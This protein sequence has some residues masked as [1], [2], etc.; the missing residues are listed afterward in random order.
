MRHP[1][2]RFRGLQWRL[3]LSYTLVTLLAILALE[4][5]VVA[6]LLWRYG[7]EQSSGNLPRIALGVLVSAVL[8]TPVFGLLGTLFGYAWTRWLTGRLRRLSDIVDAWGR[9]DLEVVARDTSDDEI[10]QLARKLNRMAEQLQMLL[11]TRRELAIVQERQRLARDLHDAVKQQVFATAMQLGAAQAV[12]DDDPGAARDLIVGAEQLVNQTQQELT[13][14]IRELRPAAL[15]DKGLAAALAGAVDDWSR[16]T[17]IAAE[18]R[19]QGERETPLIVEQALFRVAQEALAN[20]SRH[21]RA[22]SIE[23][24]LA[25]D[26]DGLTLTVTDN[27]RGFDFEGVDGKGLGLSS[28]RERVEAIGGAF[29]IGST[30]RGTRVEARVTLVRAGVL[31]AGTGREPHE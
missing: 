15:T 6:L 30:S 4:A 5:T 27:G 8:L 29:S 31:S 21:S 16:R 3:T 9:G 13:T 19:V 14:L 28:M 7:S 24:R 18:L 12:V 25:W 23:V 1:F 11:E 10:G 26:L 2:R 20:V 22:T 17:K